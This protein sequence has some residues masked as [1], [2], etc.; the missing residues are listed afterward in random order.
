L[1][2]VVTTEDV[3]CQHEDIPRYFIEDVTDGLVV[4]FSTENGNDFFAGCDVLYLHV[5]V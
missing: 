5:N 3:R 2:L 1:F 4:V